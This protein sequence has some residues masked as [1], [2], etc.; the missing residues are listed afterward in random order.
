MIEGDAAGEGKREVGVMRE[1]AEEGGREEEAERVIEPD[2]QGVREGEEGEDE[3]DGED[4]EEDEEEAQEDTVEEESEES[5]TEQMVTPASEA[6]G[7]DN[8]VRRSKKR[9]ASSAKGGPSKSSKK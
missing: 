5:E 7:Q 1:L 2:A 9:G 4:E 3:E 8:S 6:T